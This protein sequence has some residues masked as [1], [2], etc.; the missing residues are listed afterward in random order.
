MVIEATAA[1]DIEVTESVIVGLLFV[2]ALV[3]IAVT[4]VRVPY[5]VAL[6]IV[7]LVLGVSGAFSSVDLTSDLILLVFLPPLLFEGA[8]NMELVVLKRRWKQV[9]VLASAGTVIAAVAI[10]APLV[11]VPGMAL[12]LAVVLAVILAPT[13]PVS[14]LAVFKEAGVGVGL[15][16]LMEGESI[17]NDAL[18]IVLYVI[19]VDVAFGDNPLTVQHALSEFGIEVSV[20]TAVGFGV[21]LIAHRLMATL[22]DHL[23]EITL[24]LVTA[25]GA[26]LAADRLGGSGVIAVVVGALVLGNYGTRRAMSASSQVA[27]TDFWEVLA[28]LANSALFLIIGLRFHVSD[29]QGRTLVATAVA[30]VGM[31]VGRAIVAFGLL[32][33]FRRS[34]WAR[35]PGSWQV[36]VFWG[37][38]RGSIPIAL[39]LGLGDRQFAGVDPVAVVFGV[40]FFSLVVQGLTYRPLLRRLGLTGPSGEVMRNER[41]FAR[42]LA[43]QAAQRELEAMRDSGE[44]PPAPLEEMLRDLSIELD[45][46]ERD[47]SQLAHGGSVLSDHQTEEAGA[48]DLDHGNHE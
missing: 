47:L 30:V 23:V 38:L 32:A 6:V 45:Q 26:Y 7:G 17:F 4:R 44:I 31:L 8:F 28:F 10:A 24:S 36:A 40:V 3:A 16:T 29:L 42:M 34:R 20:G 18:A 22:D 12:D 41:L 2:A 37:G 39:V 43:L 13:D 46:C 35:V 1:T 15:R 25:Y 11:V 5:T 19:A 21:G 9:A 48:P 14:V 33:P 27:M